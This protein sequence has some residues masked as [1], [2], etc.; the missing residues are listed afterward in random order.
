MGHA[1]DQAAGLP[2]FD[3][4]GDPALIRTGFAV[5]DDAQWTGRGRNRLAYRY[6]DAPQAKIKRENGFDAG[7]IRRV[8]HRVRSG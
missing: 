7:R 4:S 8:R 5:A 3:Q 6:A 2:F 1:D